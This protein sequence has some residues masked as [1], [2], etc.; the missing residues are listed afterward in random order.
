[1]RVALAQNKSE[2]ALCKTGLR[3]HK[4]EKAFCD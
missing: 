3:K 2:K 4:P 1:M